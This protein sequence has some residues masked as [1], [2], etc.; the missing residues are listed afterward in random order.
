MRVIIKKFGIR[1]LKDLI[2]VGGIFFGIFIVYFLW[3][4]VINKW[5][6]INVIIIF[7]NKLLEFIYFKGKL[8]IL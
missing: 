4:M 7:K 6:V 5:V 2:I 8:V 1:V 3:I